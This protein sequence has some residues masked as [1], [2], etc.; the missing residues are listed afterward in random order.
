MVFLTRSPL[1]ARRQEQE[2]EEKEEQKEETE[3]TEKA[4]T[5]Y[6]DSGITQIGRRKEERAARKKRDRGTTEE[7]R[8]GSGWPRWF[9]VPAEPRVLLLGKAS[10]CRAIL[11]LSPLI[12]VIPESV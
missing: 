6:T 10:L 12:C 4:S 5:D 9:L 2:E 7:K 3:E 11:P 8:C 1:P